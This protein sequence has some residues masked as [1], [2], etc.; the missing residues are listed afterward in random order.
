MAYFCSQSLLL[1][2]KRISELG[3]YFAALLL[4]VCSSLPL[5]SMSAHRDSDLQVFFG[6][7]REIDRAWFIRFQTRWRLFLWLDV[8]TNKTTP[9]WSS[10]YVISGIWYPVMIVV[11]NTQQDD[12]QTNLQ[13]SLVL[14]SVPW[15]IVLKRP[16]SSEPPCE[17]G[18][19]L[20]HQW[21]RFQYWN[22]CLLIK[23]SDKG[24]SFCLLI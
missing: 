12:W 24:Q 15:C 22:A 4:L 20:L 7:E 6:R 16:L 2:L 19:A 13:C 10:F 21:R 5:N 9:L 8:A 11:G 1:T 18:R 17:A 14:L 3:W 23:W